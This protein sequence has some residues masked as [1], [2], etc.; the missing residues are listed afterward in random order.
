[1]FINSIR[2]S[3]ETQNISFPKASRSMLFRES[4]VRLLLKKLVHLVIS[5]I[6]WVKD[7]SVFVKG[8]DVLS[9]ALASYCQHTKG[10]N[11]NQTSASHKFWYCLSLH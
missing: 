4:N 11:V 1:M 5:V 7:A 9:N 6:Y 10:I 3:Q 2:N 8:F